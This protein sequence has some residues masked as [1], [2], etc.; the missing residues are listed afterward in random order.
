MG[1]Q[2]WSENFCRDCAVIVGLAPP[3]HQCEKECHSVI[4]W[5]YSPEAIKA[6]F[7]V[8]LDCFWAGTPESERP[9]YF[10][11]I[12][13]KPAYKGTGR[14]NLFAVAKSIDILEFAKDFTTLRPLGKERFKGPCPVHAFAE[15]T[16]SFYIFADKQTWWCFGACATG[17]DIIELARRLMDAGR[18]V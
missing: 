12:P 8:L 16:G 18:T 15:K 9:I 2:I 4:G 11:D 3:Q 17:G 5:K 7:R 13:P 6:A 14:G 10:M 1:F